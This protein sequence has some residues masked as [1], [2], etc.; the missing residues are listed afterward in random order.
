[1]KWFDMLWPCSAQIPH[2]AQGTTHV[3][4]TQM[5]P[6]HGLSEP[7]S[8]LWQRTRPSGCASLCKTTW[9]RAFHGYVYSVYKMVFPIVPWLFWLFL[10]GLPKVLARTVCRKCSPMRV[11]YIGLHC[12]TLDYCR[13]LRERCCTFSKTYRLYQVVISHINNQITS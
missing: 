9:R 5:H 7:Q 10:P 3:L 12:I 1:M 6:E 13:L 8:M 2:D 4:K 11:D